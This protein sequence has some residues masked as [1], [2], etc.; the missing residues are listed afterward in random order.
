VGIL[1]PFQSRFQWGA[2]AL[3]EGAFFILDLGFWRVRSHPIAR[4]LTGRFSYLPIYSLA[5]LLEGLEAIFKE[6]EIL[7]T[8]SQ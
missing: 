2:F 4:R 8:Y 1:Q 6:A 5:L 3:Q 7:V